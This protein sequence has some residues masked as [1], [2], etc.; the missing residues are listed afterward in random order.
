MSDATTRELPMQTRLM[1]VA[2]VDVEKRTVEVV[3]S[4]GA[5]VRR[6][7]FWTGKRYL[8]ELS[9][10][11][12]HV[13]MSRMAIGAPLLNNHS[14]GDL[15][16]VI[17]VVERAWI[18]NGEGKAIVRFSE[19]EDVAPILRDVQ[20][21][22]IRNVS[23]GYAVRKYEITEPDD[24][25]PIYRAVDWV[26]SE[27]SL[28]PIGA[29]QNA[30]TRGADA[31]ELTRCEFLNLSAAADASRKEP[32]MADVKTAAT[33]A[34][35]V[36]PDVEALV[37]S[38]RAEAASAA[39]AAERARVAEINDAVRAAGLESSLADEMIRS[40]VTADAARRA[41]LTKLAERSEAAKVSSKA[42]IVTVTDETE[43]RRSLVAESLLHRYDPRQTLSDGARQYR[44]LSLIE[45]SRDLLTANGV[46]TRGMDRMQ[47]A[48]RALEGTSDL[49]NIVANVANKTLRQAYQQASRTFTGWARRTSAPD[50]KTLTRVAL[51]DA[52]ALEVVN[53]SG[54]FKRGAFSDG[55]ETYQLV[56]VGKIIG[57]TRQVIVN[58][59]L[60]AFTRI[61]A[62]FGAAAA[63]YES[64]TVYGVLTANAALSDTVALFEAA[65]HKNYTSSGTVISVASLDVGRSMMRVQKTPQNVVMNLAPKFLIVPAAKETIANQYT[66]ADFV[67]A[68]SS[69]INPFKNSLQVVVEGRLDA[70]SANSWYLAADPNQVDTLEYC[71]LDG[72]DGV[73][74]E[75]R[76]GFEVDGVEIKARLD[77]AA[78]AIDYR[79]LYK[80][81][82]A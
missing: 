23:V 53:E 11:A 6:M 25:L 76:N 58:D 71:Y 66:S 33:S 17:G 57:L 78:K 32:I 13:D 81:V 61:P 75:T 79:G 55:K 67:S 14:R 27:I 68:K 38:A 40:D 18:E 41:V 37:S 2:S 44:G 4:T 54:E 24:G 3:W 80:N 21:G 35:N 42:N 45:L 19:R 56:T 59:D 9:L 36:Q 15:R 64:D 49:S 20:T 46:S 70:T 47:I 74:I 28:V 63:N 48:Q 26:P 22:I 12:A 77:F 1:P 51:S 62:L 52:P 5:Q 69:D 60:Q 30:G 31:G 50:F 65:T 73:Y 8:E 29:D 16:D 82:G 7:D 10:D 43:T 72:Q 34:A 39:V